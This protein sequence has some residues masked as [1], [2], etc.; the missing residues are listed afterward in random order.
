MTAYHCELAVLPGGEVAADVL[1]EMVGGRISAVRP[2]EWSFEPDPAEAIQSPRGPGLPALSSLD[3]EPESSGSTAGD[4]IQRLSGLVFPGFANAHSHVFH[5]ALRGRTHGEQGTFWTWRE[6]MYGL[7]ARLDPDSL[8]RL[9][10]ATYA[11]MALAGFTAVGEFHY[12]H[13]GPDGRPYDRPNV[14]GEVVV[15]AAREAGLRITLLDTCYLAGGIGQPLEGAQRRFGDADAHAWAERVTD[16]ASTLGG[17][18]GVR[19]GAAI[20]SVRAVPRQQ[21]K[22]VAAWAALH[23]TPLHMHLSEQPDE[24][25][26]CLE[27]YGATPTA[28][29]EEAGALGPMSTAVHATH[30][31]DGDVASLGATATNVCFCPTTERDLADGVGPARALLDAGARLTVGSDSNAVIDGLEEARAIELNHRLATGERGALSP[32]ELLDALTSAGHFS[33]GYPAAGALRVGARADLV[34]VRLD[35]VRTASARAAGRAS[36][37]PLILYAA[38]AGDVTDVIIDGRQVVR[39]GIHYLGDVPQL[40]ADAIEPLVAGGR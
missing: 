28:V 22:E 5:R 13:H 21:L 16:L 3:D 25:A 29:L 17:E 23:D 14:L 33:L 30:L 8:L 4:G 15:Q 9:A 1:I 32:I 10:R 11:E 35:S 12:L 19:V 39:E 6:G 27:A 2:A 20:H 37:L 18:A 40:L 38:A 24:N 7:A 36:V 34:A 31:T 26:Q